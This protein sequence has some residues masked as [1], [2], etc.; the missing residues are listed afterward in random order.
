MPL[1]TNSPK[2]FY[3]DKP[4]DAT[5]FQVLDF[6]EVNT[7]TNAIDLQSDKIEGYCM[8]WISVDSCGFGFS[9][10]WYNDLRRLV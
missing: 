2:V 5:V 4:D 8:E 10:F 3:K 6:D 7:I 9:S 1:L